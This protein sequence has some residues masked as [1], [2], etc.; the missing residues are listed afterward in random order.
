MRHTADG[1]VAENLALFRDRVLVPA[2]AESLADPKADPTLV[3]DLVGL[4][5]LVPEPAAASG[6][7]AQAAWKQLTASF[8]HAGEHYQRTFNT[9]RAASLRE[10]ASPPPMIKKV[11]F[12]NVAAAATPTQP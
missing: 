11:D 10:R 6:A 5:A 12:C 7:A 9:R 1:L 4:V 2:L 3:E 8:A